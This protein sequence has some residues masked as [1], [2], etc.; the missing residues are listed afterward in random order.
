MLLRLTKLIRG[1]QIFESRCRTS[2]LVVGENGLSGQTPEV[3]VHTIHYG[4]TVLMNAQNAG[5]AFPSQSN[6]YN[7]KIFVRFYQKPKCGEN[8]I[9][10]ERRTTRISVPVPPSSYKHCTISSHTK[11]KIRNEKRNNTTERRIYR[12]TFV[13]RF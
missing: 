6:V 5:A 13:R 10:H 11:K 1:I 12:R 9:S 3:S 4:V 2:P 7:H 8:K